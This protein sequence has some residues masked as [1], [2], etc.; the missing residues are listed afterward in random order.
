MSAWFLTDYTRARIHAAIDMAPS[1]ARVTLEDGPPRSH[2][3]NRLMWRLLN[4]FADQV[5]HGDQK[6]D[7]E[8]WKCI[9]LKAYGKELSFVPALDGLS[10]VCLGYR[11]SMLSID[12]MSG[13][14]EFL[15]ATGTEL[16]VAF[17]DDLPEP[18]T[19][20]LPAR[21]KALPA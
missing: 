5:V 17:E 4:F 12:E 19:I 10:T 1:G 16:G 13:F 21:Q 20:I 2:P 18:R 9:L 11:S 8:T 6:Y 15:F 3:Q 7:S 14:I